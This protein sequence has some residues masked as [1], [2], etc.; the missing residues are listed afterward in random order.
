MKVFL[1]GS[2]CPLTLSMINAH[3]D[4]PTC[5]PYLG[6]AHVVFIYFLFFCYQARCT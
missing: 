1:R 5:F 2:A 4:D 6:V 3:C